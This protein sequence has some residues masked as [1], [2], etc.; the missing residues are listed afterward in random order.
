MPSSQPPAESPRIAPVMDLASPPRPKPHP[1][2]ISRYGA[3]TSIVLFDEGEGFPRHSP[4]PTCW[5]VR[6]SPL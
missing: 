6:G 3:I 1:E 2:G 5:T 4:P